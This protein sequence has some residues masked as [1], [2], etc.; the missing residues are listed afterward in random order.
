MQ[1]L[2]PLFAIAEEL[3][4]NTTELVRLKT[5]QK[6]ANLGSAL[7]VRLILGLMFLFV[8]GIMSIS[9]SLFVGELLG[10]TYLG[11]LS[12]GIGFTIVMVTTLLFRP[13]LENCLNN[14]IIRQIFKN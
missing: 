5:I 3:S 12:V 13:K 6:S 8:L 4:I 1:A 2:E 9:L 10:K 11:F 7:I 14:G